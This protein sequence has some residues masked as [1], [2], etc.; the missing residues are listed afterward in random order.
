MKKNR[1]Q[2][3]KKYF[4][5][6]TRAWKIE[7]GKLIIDDNVYDELAIQLFPDL[8]FL[9]EEGKIPNEIAASFS[10]ELEPAVYALLQD[11][12]SNHIISSDLEN[13]TMVFAGY[14]KYLNSSLDEDTFFDPRLYE[15]YKEKQLNR[16]EH[17][18]DKNPIYLLAGKYEDYIEDRK[19]YRE[20]N[21]SKPISFAVLSQVLSIY[22]QKRKNGKISYYYASDGGLYPIDIY[23]YV[24][25]NRVENV[26]TGLYYY[27]P[28]ENTLVSISDSCVIT[29]EIH[30]EGNKEIF[31]NSAISIFY[32]YNA[33]VTMPKYGGIAL[34]YAAIDVGLMVQLLTTVAEQQNIGICSIGNIKFEKIKKYFKMSENSIL[35]HTVEI[36][37]I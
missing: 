3:N 27:S 23:V 9:L 33:E 37:I 11:F 22:R 6:P 29:D 5:V 12:L 10:P 21:K 14:E 30:Y 18:G 13:T 15:A 31:N 4:W 34:H 32:V 8:Y 28:I 7:N 20:F 35:L 16:I 24:K 17:F 1:L 36:G 2:K 19:T 25:E 26:L